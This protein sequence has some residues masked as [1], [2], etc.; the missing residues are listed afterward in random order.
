MNEQPKIYK[1]SIKRVRT[2]EINYISDIHKNSF[3]LENGRYEEHDP[4][5]ILAEDWF[6]K[7]A[8]DNHPHRGM[9]TVTYVIDGKLEH[10][11]NSSEQKGELHSGDAQ[12]MTAGRGVIHNEEPAEGE[13]VHLL[14]LWVNL[15]AAD[16]MAEPRYQNLRGADMPIRTEDNAVIRVYSGSSGGVQSNTKNYVPITMVEFTI[17]PGVT[18]KQDLPSSYNGFLYVIKGDG[19][20]GSEHTKARQRQVLFLSREEE[21]SESSEVEI[22]AISRLRVLLYAGQP[23]HEPIVARG[24]F[25]MNTER[26]ILEAYSDYRNG[27]FV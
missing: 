23:L 6:Q 20:F 11:D 16:K 24:P 13:T 18:V 3:I 7:G 1:R 8:F 26:Q 22:T 19:Q 12:W 17:E 15:P 4:F 27:K 21:G 2:A 9:E 14:Q 10:Y 25:V 5:L